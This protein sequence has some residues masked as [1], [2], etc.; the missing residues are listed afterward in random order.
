[1]GRYFYGFAIDRYKRGPLRSCVRDL[2]AIRFVLEGRYGFDAEEYTDAEVTVST[3][4]RVFE[5]IRATRGAKDDVIVFFS[6]HGSGKHEWCVNADDGNANGGYVESAEVQ[7]FAEQA[8][9]RH[10]LIISDSC[11]ALGQAC[12]REA[13]EHA[14]GLH[15]ELE[16]NPSKQFLAATGDYYSWDGGSK[17]SPF[18]RALTDVLDELPG[19]SSMM[20]VYIGVRTRCHGSTTTTERKQVPYLRVLDP[21][22]HGEMVFRPLP[23][24]GGVPPTGSA[25]PVSFQTPGGGAGGG[26]VVP[27]PTTGMLLSIRAQEALSEFWSPSTNGN[28][29]LV[30]LGQ[31]KMHVAKVKV[32]KEHVRVAVRTVD[33][34]WSPDVVVKDDTGLEAFFR[35]VRAAWHDRPGSTD[36][37][38]DCEDEVD[39]EEVQAEPVPETRHTLWRRE[40]GDAVFH[41]FVHAL[42]VEHLRDLWDQMGLDGS[43]R[44]RDELEAA[45]LDGFRGDVQRL[46]DV[47]DETATERAA[48]ALGIDHER[49][50]SWREVEVELHYRL[51]EDETLDWAGASEHRREN[52]IQRIRKADLQAVFRALGDDWDDDQPVADLRGEFLRDYAGTIG[53]VLRR[54]PYDALERIVDDEGFPVPVPSRRALEARIAKW[55][56]R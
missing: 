39:E 48:T 10:L 38:W 31:R 42:R 32:Y 50:P 52:L 13:V 49:T 29:H 23:R 25:A 55:L 33:G 2:H 37:E 4:R 8:K 16:R 30:F 1:M 17:L 43:G 51:R 41:K 7:K 36:E 21:L 46:I 18:A 20:E 6:G 19:P 53:G 24:A 28:G 35:D 26:S 45:L 56:K 22:L 44:L 11:Y 34:R 54:L 15:E 14:P 9:T 40:I 47:L 5:K 12:K 3:V 27:T